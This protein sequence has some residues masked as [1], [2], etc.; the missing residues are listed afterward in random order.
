MTPELNAA[1]YFNE[2]LIFKVAGQQK[3]YYPAGSFP[4]L[5]DEECNAA[6]SIDLEEDEI[7]FPYC[8]SLYA[9]NHYESEDATYD[10]FDDYH[11]PN[12]GDYE[13][14]NLDLYRL[15]DVFIHRPIDPYS[16]RQLYVIHDFD[17]TNEDDIV[18]IPNKY[19]VLC[20]LKAPFIDLDPFSRLLPNG[21]NLL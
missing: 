21:F 10:D 11:D 1:V 18:I 19:A 8:P 17:Y 13:E 15:Y 7:D 20:L 14:Q 16:E 9:E 2:P 4:L 5:D 6:P 12:E 3:E